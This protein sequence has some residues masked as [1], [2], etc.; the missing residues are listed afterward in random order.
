M[1]HQDVASRLPIL[2]PIP[3]GTGNSFVLEVHGTA[4]WQDSVMRIIR[5]LHVP[6]DLLKLTFEYETQQLDLFDCIIYSSSSLSISDPL[7]L[8]PPRLFGVSTLCTGD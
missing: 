7:P 2:A 1:S 6:F 4:G 3:A 8:A 5:G